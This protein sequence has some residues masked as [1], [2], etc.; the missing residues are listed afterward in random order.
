[1]V[2]LN[3]TKFY[4]MKKPKVSSITSDNFLQIT[5]LLLLVLFQ[6]VHVTLAKL[7][8]LDSTRFV[9]FPLSTETFTHLQRF[10]K[11]LLSHLN[12]KFQE[13]LN[14][15]L[16]I[17]THQQEE[18]NLTLQRKLGLLEKMLTQN[19]FLWKEDLSKPPRQ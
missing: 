11:D 15:L 19:L 8:L 16:M 1:M 13:S 4:Q 10:Q 12:S 9:F 2:L 17:F 5:Q 7:K 14:F 18:M 6:D 3:F